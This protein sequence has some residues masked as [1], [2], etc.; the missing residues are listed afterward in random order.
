VNSRHYERGT[1]V[2]ETAIVMAAAL[3]LLF[4]IIDFGRMLFTY[5]TLANATRQAARWAIVRG[6]G[7][8]SSGE[9]GEADCPAT[10]AEIQTY[11]QTES[12]GQ[13]ITDPTSITVT[14]TWSNT[15]STCTGYTNS[16]TA[17][18]AGCLITVTSS[19]PFNF[20]V[21]WLSHATITMTST[22]EMIMS[23]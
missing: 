1:A 9:S 17:A 20:I 22:S 18:G 10:Q 12:L 13:F 14:P 7:C 11:L 5:E 19:Y 3:M 23:Q 8:A 21:P 15:S 6:A 16:T 4:F 2:V